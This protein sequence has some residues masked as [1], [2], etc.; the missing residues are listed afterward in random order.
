MDTL[1]EKLGIDPVEIRKKNI[2]REGD[3]DACGQTTVAIGVGGCLDKVAKWIEWGKKPVPEEGP[4]EKGKGIAIANKYTV[5]M[6][7]MATVKVHSDG[8]VEVRHGSVEIGQGLNTVVAQIAAEEF[9]I[10]AN[11]VKVVYGDTAICPTDHGCVSSRSTFTTGNAVRLAC[12]DAKRR[13]LEIANIKLDA[14]I[15]K[16][17]IKGG[18]VFIT[19]EPEKAV[20]IGDLFWAEGIPL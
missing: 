1:A 16:L 15:D 9:G 10:P 13:I 20:S 6:P 18:K 7:S 8:G 11:Q 17:D 3:K 5:S 19:T 4:W 12:Q 14:S 2:L